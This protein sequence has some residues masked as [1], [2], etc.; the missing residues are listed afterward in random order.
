[1]A[2]LN[3]TL[4]PNN[5]V[6][7]PG[8][9]HGELD[10]RHAGAAHVL[11]L[12]DTYRLY[13]WGIGADGRRRICAAESPVDRPDRWCPLGS[14]LEPQPDT[15][16]NCGGPSFPFVV[17]AEGGPWLMYFGAWGRSRQDGK[18]PNSTGLA[19]SEDEGLTW[20]YGGDR[21]ILATDRLWDQSG[22]GSVCV[23]REG[24]EFRMYY[25]SIGEYFQRPPDV[26]TGHGDVIPRIGVGYAVSADGIHWTKPLDGLVVSPRGFDAEPYEYISSKPFV[27]REQ[28]GYRMWVSTFGPAYRVR[29]LTSADG[30]Q[31]Q[32]QPG[33]P[34]GDLGVG[35]QGAFDDHQRCYACVVRHE[36]QYRCWFT[37]NGFGA[38]GMGYATGRL[39]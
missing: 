35:Q 3:W 32:W 10:A 24:G 39:G 16:Y 34:D 36:G 7:R 22:T 38:T 8:A 12:G 27:L 15:D 23:L 1:M 17:R 13:Y 25:T 26:R 4:D 37:G 28:Q 30:L 21:P 9:I 19:L 33:G 29:S 18:L 20:R 11:R 5:P 6:I 14:M 31:W 2:R